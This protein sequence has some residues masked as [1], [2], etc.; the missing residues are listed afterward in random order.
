MS[1]VK[2]HI[3]N[4]NGQN[5]SGPYTVGDAAEYI[6]LTESVRVPY[7]FMYDDF[8]IEVEDIAMSA[9]REVSNGDRGIYAAYEYNGLR[10]IMFLFLR[11]DACDT[12]GFGIPTAAKLLHIGRVGKSVSISV[13]KSL[14]YANDLYTAVNSISAEA[15][16]YYET[17]GRTSVVD[18]SVYL[19]PLS[20]AQLYIAMCM[21]C[22][23]YDKPS[24][25]PEKAKD[26]PQYS[27]GCVVT[28]FNN[29]YGS[30]DGIIQKIYELTTT[31]FLDNTVA[32]PELLECVD[33]YINDS[34]RQCHSLDFIL[35]EF[36]RTRL[37]R[38]FY[39]SLMYFMYSNY[40]F[41]ELCDVRD[42]EMVKQ[43]VDANGNVDADCIKTHFNDDEFW[44][45]ETGGIKIL[46]AFFCSTRFRYVKKSRLYVVKCMNT[47]KN[48][49][50]Y[51]DGP[52]VY[53]SYDEYLI[54]SLKNLLK[55]IPLPVMKHTR[56]GV[57][58]IVEK[59]VYDV[60]KGF[61]HHGTIV[62]IVVD[63][64]ES[65]WSDGANDDDTVCISPLL[66][67]M[68][69]PSDV[70][71]NYIQEIDIFNKHLKFVI[72]NN[73]DE[74]Y[75]YL[76]MWI[77]KLLCESGKTEICI[78]VTGIE[79]VG[80]NLTIK[81]LF[82]CVGPYLSCCQNDISVLNNRFN[83]SFDKKIFVVFDEVNTIGKVYN[84]MNGLVT[85]DQIAIEYK[86]SEVQFRDNNI[87]IMVLSNNTNIFKPQIN[88]EI[89]GRLRRYRQF[90][91][92]PTILYMENKIRDKYFSLL[93]SIVDDEAAMAAWAWDT[94]KW[95][96]KDIKS[97]TNM[98]GDKM[99]SKID[100]THRDKK[101]SRLDNV[102]NDVDVYKSNMKEY[103]RSC[104][105]KRYG[106]NLGQDVVEN[107]LMQKCNN[108]HIHSRC[109]ICPDGDCL[110]GDPLDNIITFNEN[111]SRIL[112]CYKIFY[113]HSCN[114]NNPNFDLFIRSRLS[115][116]INGIPGLVDINS[117]SDGYEIIYDVFQ[118]CGDI[119][120][121]DA[122]YGNEDVCSI[123]THIF[124]LFGKMVKCLEDKYKYNYNKEDTPNPIYRYFKENFD[125]DRIKS[126]EPWRKILQKRFGNDISEYGD[127]NQHAIYEFLLSLFQTIR[128]KKKRKVQC[129]SPNRSN[130]KIR[131]I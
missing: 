125:D 63:P 71:E 80:K 112:R 1:L 51:F 86:G 15:E 30:P 29:N 46:L 122:I 116:F 108:V 40:T 93:A 128:Q 33:M 44:S 120:N 101:T 36:I 89:G 111:S 123:H 19:E 109:V 55:S 85:S 73:D 107:Y 13:R 10:Y 62:E 52:H 18:F 7:V 45:E 64:R 90:I 59:T 92:N 37:Y 65:F 81:G 20:S 58:V 28:Y 2:V 42:Y 35:T 12:N 74:N 32:Y 126:N 88:T 106:P 66:T 57:D 87:S 72:C 39:I 50:I 22:A 23:I 48:N 114:N 75:T 8:D 49:S 11:V 47:R 78:T 131:I 119:F 56:K 67:Y 53:Y 97:L 69:Y 100:N 124:A 6:V 91:C 24:D 83:S 16:N 68:N 79:G 70:V 34:M 127:D 121:C 4:E 27:R 99:N 117:E 38:Q 5:I 130:K 102:I 61:L 77:A 129:S 17:R 26:K 25:E 94:I 110:V 96:M 105:K 103:I 43:C 115:N 21:C 98:Y 113:E 3:C 82:K 54:S 118:S 76:R 60:M 31:S 95:Y 14:K 84:K 41:T 104:Y 9:F